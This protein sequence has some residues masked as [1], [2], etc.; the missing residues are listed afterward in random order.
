MAE[1]ARFGLGPFDLCTLL[2]SGSTAM[3]CSIGWSPI[4]SKRQATYIRSAITRADAESWV[5]ETAGRTAGFLV[6]TM[7]DQPVGEIELV[8]VDPEMQ[9][10]GVGT[11]F[12]QHALKRCREAAMAFVIVATAS[13]PATRQLAG[14]TK[15][16][17]SDPMPIHWNLLVAKL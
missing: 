16:W 7:D 10:H 12:N 14:R 13:D 15:T 6:L 8:A 5:F 11:A 17:G 1:C 3:T 9:G 2:G 4:G